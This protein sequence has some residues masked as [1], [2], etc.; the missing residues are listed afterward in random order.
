MRS[1]VDVIKVLP[2]TQTYMEIAQVSRCTI[3]WSASC[4]I[5]RLPD[6]GFYVSANECSKTEICKA[7]KHCLISVSLSPQRVKRRRAMSSTAG[8]FWMRLRSWQ[9]RCWRSWLENVRKEI[10]WR[11]L[12][13]GSE[14]RRACWFITCM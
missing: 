9:T 1:Q 10:E 7:G 6:A 11:G 14:S 3:F 5:S 8:I 2:Q 12:K 13:R 4:Q